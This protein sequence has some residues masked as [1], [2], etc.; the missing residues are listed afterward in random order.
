MGQLS[1]KTALA[2]RWV[3]IVSGKTEVAVEQGRGK[4]YE[5]GRI[6]GYYNDLTGK[7]SPNTL[8]DNQGVPLSLIAGGAKVHFPIAIFQ[9]AL[10][11]YDLSIVNPVDCESILESFRGCAD[12]ALCSQRADGSWDAFGPIG[13]E[14]YTVSSMAQG[15]GCSM[16]LRA[17]IAFKDDRYLEAALRVAD[18]MLTDINIGGV[19]SHEDGELFLEEYPQNPRRSVLNGWIFSLFGLYDA[20]LVD[21]RFSDPFSQ[22]LSTL[23]SHLSDYD[24]GYWSYYDLEKRIASP[25][26]HSLHVA[27]LKAL[28]DLSGNE[29][30]MEMANTYEQ[31]QRHSGNRLR[32]IAKKAVQ[33]LSEKSDAVVIQ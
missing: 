1:Q 10:G 30:F 31:Y 6:A 23:A 11:C 15:E 12:W 28:T 4:V 9:Y 13:S 22:S 33:K 29:S 24:T 14:K 27:Q 7:V 5:V 18:F 21:K 2:K 32:A 19:S 20:S 3:K 8:L 26:Y 17:S 16:L 25:A